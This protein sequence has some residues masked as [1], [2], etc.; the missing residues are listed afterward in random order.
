MYSINTWY[1]LGFFFEELVINR[2]EIDK[3]GIRFPDEEL[4]NVSQNSEDILTFLQLPKQAF[5]ATKG[6][7]ILIVR[8]IFCN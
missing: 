4:N 6:I 1:V 3:T 5:T 8:G 7:H 2:T